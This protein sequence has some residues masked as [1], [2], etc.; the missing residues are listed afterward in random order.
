MGAPSK[1]R[2]FIASDDRVVKGIADAKAPNLLHHS[3][4]E[5]VG[6]AA[7]D[8]ETAA[9]DAA[10]AGVEGETEHNAVC[11]GV[12]VSV[13]EHDLRILAA[14]FETDF[15]QVARRGLESSAPDPPF[16]SLSE[17]RSTSPNRARITAS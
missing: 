2:Y 12:E 5:V 7:F 11:R 13:G 9:G 10:L 17:S 3:P 15:F 14:E 6:D 4:A 16:H 8:H 1:L